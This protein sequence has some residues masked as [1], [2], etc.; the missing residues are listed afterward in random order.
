MLFVDRGCNPDAGFMTQE[1]SFFAGFR[2]ANDRQIQFPLIQ[3]PAQKD[4]RVDRNK[5]FCGGVGFLDTAQD[6]RQDFLRIVIRAAN[7]DW[8]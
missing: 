4:C 3:H 5:E 1:V 7:A 6:Q 8:T 2:P